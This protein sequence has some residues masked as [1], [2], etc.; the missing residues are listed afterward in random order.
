MKNVTV[1]A[2]ANWPAPLTRPA[3]FICLNAARMENFRIR[4]SNSL[5]KNH[6]QKV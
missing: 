4:I 2:I 6:Y 1:A 5:R 3:P